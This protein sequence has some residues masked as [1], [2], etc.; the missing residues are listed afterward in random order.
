MKTYNIKLL[1]A[2]ELIAFKEKYKISLIDNKIMVECTNF[3]RPT[4]H[5]L[6]KTFFL[7][8]GGRKINITPVV[9]KLWIEH[10]Q[11]YHIV[12]IQNLA[13]TLYLMYQ[14]PSAEDIEKLLNK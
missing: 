2:Q 8:A 5:Q 11:K 14:N 7:F 10:F 12:E 4:L 1:S 13:N 9:I 3:N 6:D